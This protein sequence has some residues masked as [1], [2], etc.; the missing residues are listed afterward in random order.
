MHY[1]VVSDSTLIWSQESR[2]GLRRTYRENTMFAIRSGARAS[3]LAEM[4]K[5]HLGKSA[6]VI[7]LWNLTDL[8]QTVE[9]LWHVLPAT[10]AD[11]LAT[12]SSV[13]R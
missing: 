13:G 8:I 12:R 4:L 6:P 1:L 10:P 9:G 3:D 2:G 7:V 5:A 11:F